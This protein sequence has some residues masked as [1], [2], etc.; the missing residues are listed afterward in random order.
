MWL[1]VKIFYMLWENDR[2]CNVARLI[3][4]QNVLKERKLLARVAFCQWKIVMCLLL[5]SKR[6][7]KL[8]DLKL[9]SQATYWCRELQEG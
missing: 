5:Q 9:Q 7:R 6:V 8:I 1:S 4:R 3:R 2:F